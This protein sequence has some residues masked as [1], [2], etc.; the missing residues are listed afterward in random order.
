M[1]DDPK[2]LKL[3]RRADLF[4]MAFPVVVLILWAALIAIFLVAWGWVSPVPFEDRVTAS[5]FFASFIVL[6]P[7]RLLKSFKEKILERWFPMY[8][9]REVNGLPR[10]HGWI[11]QE[12]WDRF[13]IRTRKQH[14]GIE[15]P[16]NPWSDQSTTSSL[17]D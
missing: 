5:I 2:L 6:V 8:Y 16:K 9:V 14:P 15:L 11:R 4:E 10:V 13:E 3:R 1:T 17:R 12:E 7:I